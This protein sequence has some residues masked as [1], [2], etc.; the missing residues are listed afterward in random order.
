MK[1]RYYA[2]DGRIFDIEA[3]AGTA[4]IYRSHQRDESGHFLDD[5]LS[6]PWRGKRLG[7]DGEFVWKMAERKLM[8][9]RVISVTRSV[10]DG[11][12]A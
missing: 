2:R 4:V 11:S 10:R 9:L 6:V 5:T 1:V 3:P 7:V 8:G 12:R